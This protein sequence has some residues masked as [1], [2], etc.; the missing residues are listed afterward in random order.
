MDMFIAFLITLLV[1][2]I[3]IILYKSYQLFKLNKDKRKIVRDIKNN[4]PFI[5]TTY[6]INELIKLGVMDDLKNITNSS[7]TSLN[8]F[9]AEDMIEYFDMWDIIRS[10]TKNKNEYSY[11]SCGSTQDP[12]IFFFDPSKLTIHINKNKENKNE[13][14]RSL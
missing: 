5:I 7:L 6:T 12:V 14:S 3:S 1:I 9:T 10:A 13:N 8:I 11:L 2:A 4:Q